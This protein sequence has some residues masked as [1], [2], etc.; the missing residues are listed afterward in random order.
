MVEEWSVGTYISV[1]L[2]LRKM[3]LAGSIMRV[4][5]AGDRAWMKGDGMYSWC[6]VPDTFRVNLHLPPRDSSSREA[7]TQAVWVFVL[8]LSGTC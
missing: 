8:I 7:L 5:L 1:I 4:V 6:L 3:K 2:S